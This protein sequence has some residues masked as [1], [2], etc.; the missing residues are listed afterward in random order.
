[1]TGLAGGAAARTG[2]KRSRQV[3]TSRTVGQSGAVGDGRLDLD[4]GVDLRE[5]LGD[6]GEAGGYSRKAIDLAEARSER[7]GSD[8]IDCDDLLVGLAQV[9]RGVPADVL[10]EAGFDPAARDTTSAGT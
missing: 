2:T 1:M 4:L 3:G 9:G 6:H 5:D 7:N 10:A 8:R